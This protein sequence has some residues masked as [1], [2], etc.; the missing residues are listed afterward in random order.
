MKQ[1]VWDNYL[2]EQDKEVMRLTGYGA[3][4]G[5][6]ERPVVMVIDVNY[7]FCGEKP[8][9]ITQSVLKWRTSCGEAAWASVERIKPVLKTA[10][11][12]GF[13]VIY[14]TAES[15]PSRWHAGAWAYKSMRSSQYLWREFLVGPRGDPD[16][17]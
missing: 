11:A 17:L 4:S 7:D 14:T 5:F 15:L 13:P 1:R 9:P 16:R 8:E 6:G 3:H 12:K 2:S 10:R